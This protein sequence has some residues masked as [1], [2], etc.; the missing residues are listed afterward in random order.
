MQEL[1][2]LHKK[3][4]HKKLFN[5]KFKEHFFAYLFIAIP[6]IGFLLFTAYA[7]GYSVFM[8]FTNF[9][10]IKGTYKFVE[11]QNYIDIFKEENFVNATINT[12]LMLASIP[13]GVFIG[14]ILA[15]YLKK[16][17]KGRT[18]L[19]I[20]YYLPAV[21]SSIAIM[22]VFKELFKNGETGLINSLLGTKLNWISNDPWLIKIAIVIKNIWA[23]IGGT[24]ILYLAGL[25]NIPESYYEVARI[26]GAS[27]WQQ[28][29]DITLPMTNNTSFY[30]IVTGVIGGLQ[31]YADSSVM[32]GGYPGAR[33]I[34]YY[35]WSYGINQSRYGWASAA[36][37][38]LAVIVLIITIILFTKSDVFKDVRK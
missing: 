17:A 19:T 14:L 31:S 23:G 36:S 13:V 22:I 5:A 18:F 28:F 7:L 12:V 35:I 4:P 3:K 15:V 30:L 32:G 1:D 38:L 27:R 26:Q 9:N 24:M 34:V 6:V 16:L 20:L 29:I 21:T 37:V 10:P 8:S 2:L 11:F 33:T 25:N